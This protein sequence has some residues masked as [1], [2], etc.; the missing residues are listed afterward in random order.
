MGSKLAKSFKKVVISNFPAELPA[1]RK[2]QCYRKVPQRPIAWIETCII[3]PRSLKGN[4][5]GRRT[6]TRLLFNFG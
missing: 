2:A 3:A 5:T 6:L 1:Q 4:A